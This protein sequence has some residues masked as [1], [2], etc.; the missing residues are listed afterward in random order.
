MELITKKTFLRDWDNIG[1]KDLNRAIE[2]LSKRI[3]R[4]HSISEISRMKHLRSRAH[5]Y[6][7][8]IHV[9]AKVYWI[10]CDVLNNKVRLVRIKSEVWCKKNI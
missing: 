7:I 9:Q 5:G 10:L 3:S 4:A 2:D 1:S 8:E 6:K